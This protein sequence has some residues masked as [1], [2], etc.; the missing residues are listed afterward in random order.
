M[1]GLFVLQASLFAEISPSR[2]LNSKLSGGDGVVQGEHNGGYRNSVAYDDAGTL[3]VH[4]ACGDVVGDLESVNLFQ[5]LVELLVEWLPDPAE[6][7]SEDHP[8]KHG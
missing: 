2:S 3:L 7:G 5:A 4:D 8:H 6:R 1:Y